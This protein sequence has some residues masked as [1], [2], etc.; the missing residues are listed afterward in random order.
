MNKRFLFGVLLC[1]VMKAVGMQDDDALAEDVIQCHV[2]NRVEEASVQVTC[3]KYYLRR[4]GSG[5]EMY[6]YRTQDFEIDAGKSCKFN[7]RADS[8]G[9]VDIKDPHVPTN[10]V[11]LTMIY[12]WN[13]DNEQ[14]KLHTLGTFRDVKSA[15][16]PRG[17]L[18]SMAFVL[19]G[20][21]LNDSRFCYSG[22]LE[23]E[24]ED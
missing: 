18:E 14:L 5:I 1:L 3:Y 19:K 10:P 13:A 21:D 11:L 23:K 16:L 17:L 15:T 2:F 22:M 6:Q 8:W 12:H 20:N 7:I 4:K 24:V 9:M